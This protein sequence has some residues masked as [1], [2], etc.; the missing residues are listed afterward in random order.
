MYNCKRGVLSYE[1]IIF[2][3]YFIILFFFFHVRQHAQ[4]QMQKQETTLKRFYEV[5]ILL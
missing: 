1:N 3:M 2:I 5:R 4:I